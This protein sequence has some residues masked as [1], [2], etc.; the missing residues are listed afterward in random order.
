MLIV[1]VHRFEEYNEY[2]DLSNDNITLNKLLDILFNYYNKEEMTLEQLKKIPNDMDNYV[3]D[4]IKKIKT[5]K[6]YRINIVGSLCRYEGIK[7]IDGNVY[8]LI[9]G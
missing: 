7:K 9:L 2:I 4:A 1:P 5:G 3:K 8:K 6:I